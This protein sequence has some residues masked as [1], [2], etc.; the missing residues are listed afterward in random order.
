M[1]AVVRW[2]GF[3]C[4]MKFWPERSLSVRW[5]SSLHLPLWS[6]LPT[7]EESVCEW[8]D[9]LSPFSNGKHAVALTGI[10]K[11]I[12]CQN[13]GILWSASWL[14][15][16]TMHSG[17]HCALYCALCPRR[18]RSLLSA[19]L[20]IIT[21]ERANL[22]RSGCHTL[23]PCPNKKFALSSP[24][25]SHLPLLYLPWAVF[26][27]LSPSFSLLFPLT[28]QIALLLLLLLLCL[29]LWLLL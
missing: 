7:L 14:V 28:Q 4:K 27:S 12:K 11:S 29:W 20:F 5:S 16:C 17:K 22:T 10:N 15:L 26:L 24:L 25:T 1:C 19:C 21:R 2:S 3:S 18:R 6:S 8:L 9:L 13:I 23:H